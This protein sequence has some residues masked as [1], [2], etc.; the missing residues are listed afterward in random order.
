MD[1]KENNSNVI[2]KIILD[3]RQKYPRFSEILRFLIIGGIATLIDMFMMGVVLYIFD[4]SLYP[5]FFNVFYGAVNEPSTMATIVGTAVGF[6]FGLIF[7]YIFSILY[8]FFDNKKGKTRS[9]FIIFSILSFGGLL[10]HIL[11]MWIGFNILGINEW[12]IK[13]VLTIVVMIYNYLSKKIFLFNK[14]E[15]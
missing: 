11:G 9:G 2:A 10:I 8:V 3:F 1:S 4:P 15:I 12:I 14:K 7:N 6:I 13:I 5:S